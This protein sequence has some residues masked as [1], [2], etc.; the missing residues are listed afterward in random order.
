MREKG[1]RRISRRD[2]ASQGIE[3]VEAE[4]RNESEEEE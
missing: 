1:E 3:R 2:R 4:V